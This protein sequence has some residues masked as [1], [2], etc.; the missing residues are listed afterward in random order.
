[1]LLILYIAHCLLRVAYGC[2][3][4]LTACSCLY[5]AQCLLCV[6]QVCMLLIPHYVMLMFTICLLMF[7]CCLHDSHISM[8]L[9][10]HY[11]SYV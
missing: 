11:V 3:A 8:L 7:V 2:H 10:T 1:M 5:D 6:G 4:P 9:T